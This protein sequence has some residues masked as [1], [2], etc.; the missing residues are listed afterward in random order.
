MPGY[1]LHLLDVD[2]AQKPR[3]VA[4]RITARVLASAPAAATALARS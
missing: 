2:P 3:P 1:P 4:A